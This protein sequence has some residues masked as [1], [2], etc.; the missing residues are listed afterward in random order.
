[1]QSSYD[2]GTLFRLRKKYMIITERQCCNTSKLQPHNLCNIDLIADEIH[3]ANGIPCKIQFWK[4]HCLVNKVHVWW[5][6][7]YRCRQKHRRRGLN[8][9]GQKSQV[10]VI[11]VGD[12]IY[13]S[14]KDVML[15][16]IGNA[17]YRRSSPNLLYF[18]PKM[19]FHS[20]NGPDF[21]RLT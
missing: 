19:W 15:K 1:M 21:W 5:G 6:Y 2:W 18:G 14:I 20:V 17:V 9:Y 7:G 11:S 3:E 12:Q 8:V 4:I 13:C 16:S 10:K